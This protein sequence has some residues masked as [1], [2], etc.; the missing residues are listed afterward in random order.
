MER[1]M[2]LNLGRNL[3]KK[4]WMILWAKKCYLTPRL[5]LLEILRY[6]KKERDTFIYFILLSPVPMAS[7]SSFYYKNPREVFDFID[8]QFTL[9]PDSLVELTKT[10]LDEIKTGLANYNQPMAM[11]CAFSFLAKTLSLTCFQSHICYRRSQWYRDWVCYKH[12][13]MSCLLSHNSF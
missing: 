12:Q 2:S 1:E 4:L 10:F 9:K 3:S 6:L 7:I 5:L 8:D 13:S 11:M